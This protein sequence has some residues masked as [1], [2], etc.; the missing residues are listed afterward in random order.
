[1]KG[2]CAKLKQTFLILPVKGKKRPYALSTP[3]HAK[4]FV[5]E[6]KGTLLASRIS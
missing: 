3:R 5:G 2:T 4:W 1:M 6:Q